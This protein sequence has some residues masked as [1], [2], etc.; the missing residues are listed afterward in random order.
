MLVVLKIGME[1]ECGSSIRQSYARLRQPQYHTETGYIQVVLFEI[2]KLFIHARYGRRQ[3]P[4][5]ING[6]YFYIKFSGAEC[7]EPI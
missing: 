4:P 2:L 7:R 5:A 1:M 3:L 6:D